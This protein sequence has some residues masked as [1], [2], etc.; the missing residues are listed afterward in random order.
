MP[1]GKMSGHITVE[2]IKGYYSA[3]D[4]SLVSWNTLVVLK[5]QKLLLEILKKIHS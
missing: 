3:N 4:N 2:V 1:M 5:T